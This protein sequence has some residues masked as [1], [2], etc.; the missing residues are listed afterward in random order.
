MEGIENI[1]EKGPLL[2]LP[3]HLSNL[4]GPLVLAMYPQALEMVGPRDFK[5][6]PFK[7]LM[8]TVYGNM[9]RKI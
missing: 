1:P 7:M 8:M 6:E 9:P 4:D 2:V 5:M 3:N